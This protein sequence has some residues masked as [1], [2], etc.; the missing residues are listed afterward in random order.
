M[1]S[2]SVPL[3]S[4]FRQV[5]TAETRR[6]V[7]ALRA[8]TGRCRRQAASDAFASGAHHAKVHLRTGVS[9]V[10]S[11]RK[12][13]W[14]LPG[15]FQQCGFRA[16]SFDAAAGKVAAPQA[17]R[18]FANAKR[19]RNA[20]GSSNP[21]ASAIMLAPDPLPAIARHRKPPQ[22]RLLLLTRHHRRLARHVPPPRINA[23][24][25]ITTSIR[26]QCASRLRNDSTSAKQTA[27]SKLPGAGSAG[28][29]TASSLGEKRPNFDADLRAGGIR[30]V[31][32]SPFLA[33]A[34]AGDDSGL[35]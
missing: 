19:F 12:S 8:A 35:P 10:R 21:T 25:G 13:V 16:T 34:R 24:N 32:V 33:A 14:V 1:R 5:L 4:R 28:L 23:G 15:A 7:A 17:H 9:L 26:W 20:R 3:M 22:S 11:R 30:Q 31:N 27:R 2:A 6:I 18:V 29:F